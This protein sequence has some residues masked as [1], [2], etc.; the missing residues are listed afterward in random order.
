M[1]Y[2]DAA[3]CMTLSGP[4]EML[5]LFL[6]DGLAEDQYP[7][8]VE[9]GQEWYLEVYCYEDWSMGQYE[10][11]EMLGIEYLLT[12]LSEEELAA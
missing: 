7:E 9:D 2:S 11:L 5:K 4:E 3:Y 1:N 12:D 6:T 8:W 10:L